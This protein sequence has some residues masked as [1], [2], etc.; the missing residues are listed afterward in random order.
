MGAASSWTRPRHWQ[1]SGPSRSSGP[2]T[3]FIAEALADVEDAGRQA[4]VADKVR[5]LCTAFPL[6]RDR[7]LP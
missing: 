5:E 2:T 4:R 3:G 6:Y 1:S 7:L